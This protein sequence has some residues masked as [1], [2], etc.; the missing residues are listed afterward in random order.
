MDFNE[1]NGRPTKLG[2]DGHELYIK[3]SKKY[4]PGEAQ[5]VPVLQDKTY[6]N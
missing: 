1:N 2:K 5:L 6:G 4:Q 3:M